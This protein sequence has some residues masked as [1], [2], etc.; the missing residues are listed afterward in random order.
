VSHLPNSNATPAVLEADLEIFLRYCNETDE[1]SV[2]A[3][4]TSAAAALSSSQAAL[5]ASIASLDSCLA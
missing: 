2:I 5:N 3:S 1:V 4:T